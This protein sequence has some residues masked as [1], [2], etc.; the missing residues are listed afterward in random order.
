LALA[1]HTIRNQDLM[2]PFEGIE[3]GLTGLY[4]LNAQ[5]PSL[6]GG[7]LFFTGLNG[8]GSSGDGVAARP[9]S[10]RYRRFKQTQLAF[11]MHVDMLACWS[12]MVIKPP[13]ASATTNV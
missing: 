5:R 12:C 1:Q 10:K 3:D 7:G 6:G 2:V 13:G 8:Q 9:A 11:G 4:V